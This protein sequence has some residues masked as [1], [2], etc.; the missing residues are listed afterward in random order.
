MDKVEQKRI[1]RRRFFKRL[2]ITIGVCAGVYCDAR[3]IEPYRLQISRH[4]VLL[5]EL[6]LA[7][8]GM[9]IAQLTDLH[10]GPVTPTKTIRD[11]IEAVARENPQLIALTG[12]FVQG[13][14]AQAVGLAPLLKPLEAAPFGVVA[15]LGN[16]DYP[17]Y[18]GD[19]VANALHDRA[20]VRVLRN[21]NVT[22]APGL[23]VVGI[24]DTIRGK[25][26]A[27]RAF[28]G[29]SDRAACVFLTHNP[30][31]I[32]GATRRSCVALAGHTHGGQVRFPGFPAHRPPGM[33]GFP[34]IEGWGTFD[35]AQLFISRGVGL[36]S[37]PFRFFCPPEVALITL[38]RGKGAPETVPDLAGRAINKLSRFGTD[39]VHRRYF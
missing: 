34:M 22:V 9:V 36:G 8:D 4:T 33:A 20:G 2:G 11:A 7:L 17:K 35:R 6:P 29:A 3:Y 16:H 39:L 18:S 37:V 19:G 25:P 30:V 12:D 23:T 38:K 10:Y 28:A 26:D 5:P 15:C 31:G 32:W 27:V 21:E 14:V 1:A 24:E 13:K